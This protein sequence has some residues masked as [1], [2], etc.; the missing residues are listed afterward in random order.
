MSKLYRSTFR[1]EG[2]RYERTST[3]S[4]READRK[5]DKLKDELKD[6]TIG[7]SGKMQV[8]RWS[9][10][11]LETYKKP[12][13]IEKSYKNYKRYVDNVINPQIGGLRVKEVTDIH[14]QKI[15][16]TR[17]GNSLSDVKHLLDTIKSIF[18]KSERIQIDYC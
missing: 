12:M 18:K 2:R 3:I 5:A 16:N 1:Y 15:L 10:E 13:V 17:A 14:L 8:K 11:W 9:E 4:Q 7:I 6:G